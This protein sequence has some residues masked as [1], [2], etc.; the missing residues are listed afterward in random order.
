M[1]L[2]ETLRYSACCVWITLVDRRPS[3]TGPVKIARIARPTI[4]VKYAV[5]AADIIIDQV[6]Q[7]DANGLAVLDLLVVIIAILWHFDLLI[8]VPRR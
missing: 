8:L 7:A 4:E 5:W 1:F 3:V 2:L 6:D